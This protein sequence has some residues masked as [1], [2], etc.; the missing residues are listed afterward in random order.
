MGPA[1]RDFGMEATNWHC[2]GASFFDVWQNEGATILSWGEKERS[3]GD[4]SVLTLYQLSWTFLLQNGNTY[5]NFESEY[6]MYF[7]DFT[8]FDF[9]TTHEYWNVTT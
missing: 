2:S 6:K 1:T 5:L 8:L 7:V 9:S 3:W 4:C